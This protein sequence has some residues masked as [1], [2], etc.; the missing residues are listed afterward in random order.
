M[1]VRVVTLKADNEDFGQDCFSGEVVSESQPLELGSD[2]ART[3]VQNALVE[4]ES[5]KV[6]QVEIQRVV[7]QK[8][9]GLF[10]GEPLILTKKESGELEALNQEA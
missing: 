10:R 6:D 4:L 5:G 7:E 3:A 9:G 8:P 1:K 2:L